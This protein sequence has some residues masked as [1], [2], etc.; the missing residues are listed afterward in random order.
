[1]ADKVIGIKIVIDGEQQI[2]DLDKEL[3]KVNKELRA[4]QAEQK[5]LNKDIENVDKSSQAYDDLLKT[6]IDLQ[7][8]LKES[9]EAQKELNK[10]FEYTKEAVGSYNELSAELR[11]LTKEFKSMSEAERNADVGKNTVDRINELKTTLKDLDKG[12][13][14][15]FRNVG[16][17]TDSINESLSGFKSGFT[18]AFGGFSAAAAGAFAANALFDFVKGSVTAF[19]EAENAAAKLENVIVNIGGQSSEALDRLLNQADQLEMKTFGFT[20]EQIQQQQAALSVFGLTVSEIEKLTPLIL[21]YATVTG[22]D[23]S[24]ATGDVTNALLGKQKALNEVGI[25][26]DKDKIS[27]DGLT[28]SLAKFG[29]SAERNLDKGVNKLEILS[30]T[31]GKVQETL[32]GFIAKYLLQLVNIFDKGSAIID[33]FT[34]AFP[35]LGGAMSKISVVATN[36]LLPFTSLLNMVDKVVQRVDQLTGGTSGSTAG[37]RT[38]KKE[39]GSGLFSEFTS[40]LTGMVKA[41]ATP[42]KQTVTALAQKEVKTVKEAK[43]ISTPEII[44]LTKKQEE[45]IQEA[46][47]RGKILA[48]GEVQKIEN[49][50][51]QK[52]L[53]RI[54]SNLTL[55]IN[56]IEAGA[57]KI[58]A[59]QLK[60]NENNARLIEEQLAQIENAKIELQAQAFD[61][62]LLLTET[63]ENNRLSLV[64]EKYDKEAEMLKSYLDK[65]QI[66]QEQYDKEK[67]ASQERQAAE[68]IKIR[69]Q[70][71]AVTKTITIA[72]IA[73]NLAKE[74]SQINSNIGVNADLTQTLRTILTV[75][76]I[77]RAA[78][79]TGTVLSQKF[80]KG[81][82]ISGNSH[83]RGGVKGWIGNRQIELE[84]GEVVINKRSSELFKPLLSEI[85]AKGGGVRFAAGGVIPYTYQAGG[86]GSGKELT[87]IM[88]L[89]QATNN[90]IDKLKVVNVVSEVT[91]IQ[92]EQKTVYQSSV[93]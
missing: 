68:E 42:D 25:F 30:D 57:Q 76:A 87:A 71:A 63:Y 24:T 26:L 82:L 28:E 60:V 48:I 93:I 1:M 72:E 59:A 56:A 39:K 45:E 88:E 21:D 81:G 41:N 10:T 70:V 40:N 2:S 64:Q 51:E 11:Q 75:A 36:L 85:N 78:L 4:M 55:E 46:A 53:E 16:N 90:R 58:L 77:G 32:G 13:G 9:K 73:I 67:A 80:A 18:E 47:I 33:R 50:A 54:E 37:T 79:Q 89:I 83:E 22:K 29:G 86:A 19:N 38:A 6:Q 34:N 27:V 8:K 12:I 17:Y 43:E 65:K 15:N 7:R 3:I 31:V 35:A 49:I 23:L 69:K 84:G 62:A 61:A 20:A 52:K 66:T 5:K 74:I 14:D 92:N 91:T 44:K